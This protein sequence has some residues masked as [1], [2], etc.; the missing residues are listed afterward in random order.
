MFCPN[1]TFAVVAFSSLGI[2][3]LREAQPISE[4]AYIRPDEYRR[5]GMTPLYDALDGA[6][7]PNGDLFACPIPPLANRPKQVTCPA[8]LSF[9]D[10]RVPTAACQSQ[11]ASRETPATVSLPAA[12]QPPR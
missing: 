6:A 4:V 7:N 1:G 12:W 3:A 11:V 10:R 9:Q 2:T 5:N 8:L